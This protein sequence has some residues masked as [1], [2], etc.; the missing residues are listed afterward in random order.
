MPSN[1]HSVG[2]SLRRFA[3]IIILGEN[4]HFSFNNLFY[5][6]FDDWNKERCFFVSLYSECFLTVLSWCCLI[7]F[8][9]LSS[10]I[11]NLLF[12]PYLIFVCYF[13]G[14]MFLVDVNREE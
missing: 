11:C 4:L 5:N 9:I 6:L 14:G 10:I 3:K 1:V 13:W 2:L 8:G 12:F 7:L